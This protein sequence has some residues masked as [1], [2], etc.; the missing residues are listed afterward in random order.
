MNALWYHWYSTAVSEA[1]QAASEFTG[2]GAWVWCGFEPMALARNLRKG[3][4]NGS[5]EPRIQKDSALK[6]ETARKKHQ[7]WDSLNYLESPSDPK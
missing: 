7:T 2:L 6:C 4:P 1:C 5:R 3:C